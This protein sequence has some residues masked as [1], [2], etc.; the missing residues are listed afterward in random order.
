MTATM[1]EESFLTLDTK[2]SKAAGERDII[3][4]IST[5]AVDRDGD[6]LLPAGLDAKEFRENPVMLFGHDQ[7]KLPIGT[8]TRLEKQSDAIIAHGTLAT[9]P[10]QHPMTE[11]WGPDTILHLIR[12]GVIRAVSVGFM[13]GEHREPTTK[14]VSRYGDSVRRIVS[15]WRLVEVSIVPIP[16]NQDALIMA[17]GKAWSGGRSMLADLL[18]LPQKSRRRVDIPSRRRLNIASTAA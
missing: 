18:N 11:E 9:R 8:W 13:I 15:K 17:V 2:I 10:P 7:N 6:V 3:A 12:E 16:A 14:D 4:R 5:N 1:I